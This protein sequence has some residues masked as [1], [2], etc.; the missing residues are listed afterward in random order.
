MSSSHDA[1]SRS[2]PDTPGRGPVGPALRTVQH[3]PELPEPGTGGATHDVHARKGTQGFPPEP[4]VLPARKLR[5]RAVQ[6]LAEGPP[7][8]KGQTPGGPTA[9][10]WP[11][12]NRME[13]HEPAAAHAESS[14][15]GGTS[16][17]SSEKEQACG[18]TPSTGFGM[19]VLVSAPDL[20]VRP[21]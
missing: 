2:A 7:T 13:G 19:T 20:K 17:L 15:H 14:P 5:P 11:Q 6:H 18:A 16:R 21:R 9:Q 1:Q 12:F 3:R 8:G 10:G 4:P